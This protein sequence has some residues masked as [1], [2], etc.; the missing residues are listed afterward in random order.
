MGDELCPKCQRLGRIRFKKIRGQSANYYRYAFFHHNDSISEHYIDKVWRKANPLAAS[1]IRIA[2]KL[3]LFAEI[4]KD[5]YLDDFDTRR[6]ISALDWFDKNIVPELKGIAELS[7]MK[8]FCEKRGRPLPNDPEE[9]LAVLSEVM[10]RV[11][12]EENE[13]QV[14]S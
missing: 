8:Y 2:D 4:V 11:E 3:S 10:E 5:R 6:L 1:S 7:E 9:A 12:K 13:R 14:E